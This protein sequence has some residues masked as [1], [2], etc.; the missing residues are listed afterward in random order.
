MLDD[1][2]DIFGG[3]FQKLLAVFPSSPFNG[4]VVAIGNND[5]LGYLNWF[6]PVTECLAVM[7]AWLLAIGVYYLWSVLARWIRVVG[8]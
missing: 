6:F 4:L 8:S 2:S 3:L 1:L 7:E 5:W